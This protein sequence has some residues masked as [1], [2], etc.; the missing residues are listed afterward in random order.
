MSRDILKNL[1]L[2][3][4][5]I[6]LAMPCHVHLGGGVPSLPGVCFPVLGI[7]SDIVEHYF[8]YTSPVDVIAD[9]RTSPSHAM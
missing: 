9:L 1:D 7:A 4:S 6:V 5:L 8:I 2:G 3:L